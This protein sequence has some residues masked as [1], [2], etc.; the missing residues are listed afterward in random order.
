[1]VKKPRGIWYDMKVEVVVFI[2]FLINFKF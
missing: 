2:I 1:L